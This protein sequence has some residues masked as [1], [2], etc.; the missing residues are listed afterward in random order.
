MIFNDEMIEELR[1]SVKDRLSEKRYIHTVGVEKMAKHLG[2]IILSEKTDEL[3]VA[4]LLHD[5]TKELPYTEQLNLL[6]TSALKYTQEDIDIKPAL[7]AISAIPIVK[8]EYSKYV[9][10]DVLSAIFNHTLGNDNM[11]VFDEIIFISDYTEQGRTYPAC[12]EVRDYLLKNID[13][14]KDLADNLNSLHIAM[15]MAINYTID[16]LTKR[17]EKIHPKTYLTKTYFERLIEK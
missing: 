8:K 17:G 11:S 4:A 1:L 16:S 13:M 12:I 5:I 14:K 6:K 2:D 15:L 3:C 10:T 7:H 9:T